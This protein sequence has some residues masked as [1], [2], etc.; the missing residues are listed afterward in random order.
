MVNRAHSSFVE[1]SFGRTISA[2]AWNSLPAKCRNSLGLA[3]ETF[4]KHLKT[5]LFETAFITTAYIDRLRLRIGLPTY[6]VF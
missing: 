2:T 3:V 4:R 6:G 1:R 5:Y